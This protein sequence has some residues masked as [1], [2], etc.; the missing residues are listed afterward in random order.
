[1]MNCNNANQPMVDNF[2]NYPVMSAKDLPNCKN[3]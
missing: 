3:F 1:M 2:I